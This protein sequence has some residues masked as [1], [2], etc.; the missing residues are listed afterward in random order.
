[1]LATATWLR[2]K[3]KPATLPK[4]RGDRDQIMR[5]QLPEERRQLLPHGH[6]VLA[7]DVIVVEEHHEQT[8]VLPRGLRPMFVE[9]Q[10]LACGPWIVKAIVG[11]DEL[12]GADGLDFAAFAYLEVRRGEVC[13]RLAIAIVDGYVHRDRVHAGPEHRLLR[14]GCGGILRGRRYRPQGDAHERDAD[15][16]QSIPKR[17]V[18]HDHFRVSDWRGPALMITPTP[19]GTAET[20]RRGH[21]ASGGRASA[22]TSESVARTR[23]AVAVVPLAARGSRRTRS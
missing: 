23:A 14:W 6:A 22:I 13:H 2:E 3:V 9:R 10:N 5:R 21:H 15:S 4:W 1:M 11:L 19:T 12:E 17:G 20:A 16:H 18:R 8:V 7:A